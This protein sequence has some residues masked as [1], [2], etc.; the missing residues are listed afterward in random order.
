VCV[1]PEVDVA[2]GVVIGALAVDAVR[3][4]PARRNL[5]LAA[6]PALLAAHSLVEAV[7]WWG[8]RDQV[9]APWG[10]VATVVYVVIAFVMLPTL[11][12]TA[13]L[14]R[15]ADRR[16]RH[17]LKALLVVG[18][19]VS[20]VMLAA[21]VDGP[22]EAT[23]RAHVIVYSVGIPVAPLVVSAYV[24]AT[25]GAGLLS[26][27]R[28]IRGFAVV[29]AIA[30]AVLVTVST[31]ALTSLWCGWA[32]VTSAA[33]ALMLRHDGDPDRSPDAMITTRR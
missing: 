19:V 27:S 28:L 4:R 23:A 12:P 31:Q 32:A 22:V 9:P 6:I 17:A 29:N 5:A 33:I 3:S 13:V 15:E 2:A 20:V 1:S 24:A 8:T 10:S 14:A 16:R 30:V 18:A 25:C 26:S 21:V 11:L 7:V